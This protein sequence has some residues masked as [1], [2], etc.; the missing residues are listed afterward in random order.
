M[1]LSEKGTLAMNRIRIEQHRISLVQTFI[2]GDIDDHLKAISI[3]ND[4]NL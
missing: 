4:I 1:R 3:I 2:V